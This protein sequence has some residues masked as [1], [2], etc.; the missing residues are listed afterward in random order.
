M[1][2]RQRYPQQIQPESLWFKYKLLPKTYGQEFYIQTIN[3]SDITLATGPAGCGKT[4][5]VARLALEDLANNSV[6]R[7]VVT[8]PILEAA[9]EEIGFLPGEIEE[10]VKP[11]FQNIIDA[12][13][14]HIGPTMTKK[15]IDSQKIIFSPIAYLRGASLNNAFIISDE[16]Q[17]LTKKGIK[18]LMTRIG[19]GSKMVLNGDADQVDLPKTSDSGLA[20]AIS[21]L[22]GKNSKIG[23]V[24]MNRDDIQRNPLIMTILDNL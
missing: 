8:K 5:I 9:D 22:R 2:K 20:H 15:L 12:F 23:V 6:S 10:K 21:R 4:W 14:D 19:E 7:I 1:S 18:L 17:N 16:A 11:Y 13:E 3:E 24:E